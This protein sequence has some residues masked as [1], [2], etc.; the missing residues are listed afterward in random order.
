MLPEPRYVV[1]EIEGWAISPTGANHSRPPGIS[2]Q[3][4]D[5]HL[6]YKLLGAWR[7]EDQPHHGGRVGMRTRVRAAA[8][9]HAARLNDAR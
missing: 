1:T 9:E 2:C 7:T 3:V 4:L 5:S 8:R 6:N